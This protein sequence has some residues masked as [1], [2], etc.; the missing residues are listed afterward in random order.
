M[1]ASKS[2]VW[3]ITVCI[4]APL[5]LGFAWPTSSEEVQQY[6]VFG[7]TDITSNI[8]GDTVPIFA[9]YSGMMNQSFVYR[10]SEINPVPVYAGTTTT[11]GQLPVYDTDTDT[12][13]QSVTI[14]TGNPVKVKDLPWPEGIT[15]GYAAAEGNVP[16]I[17]DGTTALMFSYFPETGQTLYFG[18][19]AVMTS[20]DVYVES[21]GG[22]LTLNLYRLTTAD[23]VTYADLS[24]GIVMDNEEWYN[25]FV[26]ESATIL[27]RSS[28][29]GDTVAD[30]TLIRP[31]HVSG[32]LCLWTSDGVVTASYGDETKGIGAPGTYA[33]VMLEFDL[34]GM[35]ATVSGLS[36]MD[37]FTDRTYS[38]TNSVTFELN[39]VS[40]TFTS[41][42][43]YGPGT[44]YLV[45]ETGSNIGSRPG[46]VDDTFS[47]DGY[48][49]D[50]CWQLY[51][52]DTAVFGSSLT[53]GTQTYD[54]SRT[55]EVE[56]AFLDGTSGSVKLRNMTVMSAVVDD[57]RKVFVNQGLIFEGPS[58][59]AYPVTFGGTWMAD[60]LI[61][62]VAVTE[63]TQYNWTEGGFG[64][65]MAAFCFAGLITDVLGFIAL[66]LYGRGMGQRILPLLIT[67][68][69]IAAFYIIMMM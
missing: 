64:F 31:D 21:R 42:Y 59:S 68:A 60:V 2:I 54:V 56:V 48:Y 10:G 25:G 22:T 47:P 11:P 57:V 16:F 51:L 1:N 26:N 6:E 61:F 66:A 34:R 32:N 19:D 45:V 36:G 5:A 27:I 58:S 8:A 62:D 18:D 44:E 9:S 49:P 15:R 3:L 53:L 23:P 38:V 17:L 39:A 50:G 4:L 52:R 30:Q 33:F 29:L 69:T 37:D 28:T 46:I 12:L 35:T 55:G 63:K 41:M 67:F 7:G 43:L 65:D 14:T 40:P 20:G 13:I 24:Q